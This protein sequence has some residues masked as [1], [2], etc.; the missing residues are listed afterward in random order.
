MAD[1]RSEPE[2]RAARCLFLRTSAFYAGALLLA[3]AAEADNRLSLKALTA[4]CEADSAT[5]CF[6]AGRRATGGLD[7]RPDPRRAAAFFHRAASLLER[8]CQGGGMAACS[9]LAWMYE[10]VGVLSRHPERARDLYRRS[11]DGDQPEACAALGDLLWHRLSPE[12]AAQVPPL[13]S[14]ACDGGAGHGCLK[15]AFIHQNWSDWRDPVRARQLRARGLELL[16]AK[17]TAGD[18]PSCN[19]LIS[20][21]PRETARADPPPPWLQPACDAGVGQ[22][23]ARLAQASQD[24]PDLL[25]SR[26]ERACALGD[27]GGC[28]FAASLFREGTHGVAR[29]EAEARRFAQAACYLGWYADCE[30]LCPAGDAGACDILAKRNRERVERARV[31]DDMVPLVGV[32]YGAPAGFAASLALLHGHVDEGGSDTVPVPETIVA[33]FVDVG[34]GTGGATL[35]AGC[36]F[37]LGAFKELPVGIPLAQASIRGS[38]VRT[39]GSPVGTT[40]D[41]TYAGAEAGLGFALVDARIGYLWRVDGNASARDT[42]VT[43]GVGLGF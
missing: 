6:D 38:L 34:V 41:A 12:A 16:E 39:W 31:R 27:D 2:R 8:Q 4:A 30:P 18:A 3:S 5:A 21:R 35:G 9:R 36:A 26:L 20:E 11:C 29:D 15:L 22:A 25:V 42:M 43:W 1:H 13:Y 32:R 17:C 37:A 19:E 10:N 14:R 28:R 23:C 40:P 33:P 7:V 24:G